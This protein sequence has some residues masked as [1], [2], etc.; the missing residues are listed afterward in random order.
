M[1]LSRVA[2]DFMG[3]PRVRTATRQMPMRP[4]Q[5]RKLRPKDATA[6]ERVDFIVPSG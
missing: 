5:V 6:S 1:S 2:L 4:S 3:A